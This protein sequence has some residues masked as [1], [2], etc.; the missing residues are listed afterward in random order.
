MDTSKGDGRTDTA[1]DAG[2]RARAAEES[3]YGRRARGTRRRQRET[4]PGAYAARA[5]INN[6]RAL[7]NAPRETTNSGRSEGRRAG[8]GRRVIYGAA[9]ARGRRCTTNGHFLL[10]LPFQPLTCLL[11][12][13]LRPP[14]P[15][16]PVVAAPSR[17][18]SALRLR[19]RPLRWN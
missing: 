1:T 14:P 3:H 18:S 19:P 8:Q 13:E 16:P 4:R 10:I 9:R 2:V 5:D 17:S 7:S 12:V 11:S 6:E 15:P